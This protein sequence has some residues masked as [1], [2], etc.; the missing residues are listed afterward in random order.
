METVLTGLRAA[1]EPTRLR[2]LALLAHGDLT[3]SELTHILGQ[4]QPRVSRHLKL[5]CEAGLLDRFPEGTWVFYRMAGIGRGSALAKALL[6]LLPA[7]DA[8]LALDQQRL[9]AVRAA[10]AARAQ[11]YFK[12]NASRWNEIRSLHVDEREVEAALVE[13]FAGLEIGDLVDMGTG[14][15]R[16]LEVLAPVF[17]RGIGIDLSREMLSMARANLERAGLRHC[18]VRQGDITQLPLAAASADAVT[19]HQV[20]HYAADPAAVVA[21]AARVLRP[22]GILVVVDFAPHDLE[23]LRDQHAHRRLGFSDDEVSGWLAAAGL[24]GDGITRLPGKMLNV[25]LWR[26]RRPASPQPVPQSLHTGASA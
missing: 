19:L 21:E 17:E 3:V 15:G 11:D 12:E 9:A 18:M 2:M 20:L 10:R 25:V 1:A 7:D 6:E 22:G 14:T 23:V 8:V 24:V 16:A 4:S 26:A 5:M 13:Q